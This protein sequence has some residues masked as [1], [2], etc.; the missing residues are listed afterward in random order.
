[1][2][3][4]I[5]VHIN[6]G[7]VA[8]LTMV[9]E[10]MKHPKKGWKVAYISSLTIVRGVMKHPRGVMEHPL[11]FKHPRKALFV[12]SLI[13]HI[14]LNGSYLNPHYLHCIY[15]PSLS[16]Q[17][18][19]K[20]NKMEHFVLKM[21]MDSQLWCS[22]VHVLIEAFQRTCSHL[23]LQIK[24]YKWFLFISNVAIIINSYIIAICEEL[25]PF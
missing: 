12:T 9:G 17:G 2:Q 25:N 11:N 10:V 20:N 5:D 19:L 22:Y 3:Y 16:L 13:T 24:L 23:G 15:K 1:M 7:K 21:T 8:S 4:V 6:V 18:H 14:N